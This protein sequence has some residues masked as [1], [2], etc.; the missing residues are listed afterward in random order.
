M[1][2]R[3]RYLLFLLSILFCAEFVFGQALADPDKFLLPGRESLPKIFLVGTF[4]FE[5]YNADAYKVEKDKQVDILS[6]QKQKE[7]K[8][9]LDYIAI[10]KPTKICIEA[11]KEWKIMDSYRLYKSGKKN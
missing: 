3:I 8:E 11:H 4:H 9:L 10:F 2:K 5:Y 7:L 1:K 6:V